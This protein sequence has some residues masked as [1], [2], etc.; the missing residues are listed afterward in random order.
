MSLYI[1]CVAI[2]VKHSN[3]LLPLLSY[4]SRVSNIVEYIE[5]LRLR[6]IKCEANN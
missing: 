2:Y 6:L 4:Y 5:L 3:D 1:H